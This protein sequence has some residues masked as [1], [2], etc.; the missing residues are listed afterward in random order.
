MS[1]DRRILH[2][3]GLGVQGPEAAR[4]LVTLCKTKA[5]LR[6]IVEGLI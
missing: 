6:I 4:R 2:W 3:L 1:S 5:V